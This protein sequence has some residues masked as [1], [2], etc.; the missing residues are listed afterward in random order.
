MAFL[1]NPS[2]HTEHILFFDIVSFT[3][4][5]ALQDSVQAKVWFESYCQ[6]EASRKIGF[7]SIWLIEI[8]Y[9]RMVKKGAKQLQCCCKRQKLNFQ[10]KDLQLCILCKRMSKARLES[11]LLLAPSTGYKN[12]IASR[13]DSCS[14][15]VLRTRIW[16]E[17]DF[18][19][20]DKGNRIDYQRLNV[21]QTCMDSEQH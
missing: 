7:V 21:N 3:Q 20:Q 19:R 2:Y 4:A 16:G 18:L 9:T 8:N 1:L 5:P 11:P 6:V 14:C 17:Q 13:P 10:L 15:K 12:I